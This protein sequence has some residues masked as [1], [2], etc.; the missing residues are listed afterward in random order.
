ML[1]Y[2][3]SPINE[4]EAAGQQSRSQTGGGWMSRT[5]HQDIKTADMVHP[6]EENMMMIYC[7][8]LS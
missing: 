8:R 1:C 3:K 7:C 4:D 5:R 6:I 2:V